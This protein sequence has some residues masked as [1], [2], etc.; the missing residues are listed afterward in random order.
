MFHSATKLV[1][2]TEHFVSRQ[3]CKIIEEGGGKGYTMV[4]AGGKGSHHLHPTMEK[5]TVIEGFDNIKFEVIMQDRKLA[6]AIAERVLNEC[7]DDY[8]GVMYLEDVQVCR[9]ERF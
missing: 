1:V 7:F 6:E 9:P 4:P 5:A 2:I 3:V 8:P